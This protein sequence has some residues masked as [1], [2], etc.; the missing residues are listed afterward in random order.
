ML[1]HPRFPLY[2]LFEHPGSVRG[3]RVHEVFHRIAGVVADILDFLFVGLGQDV[4][5]GLAGVY[6]VFQF[7]Y[8]IRTRRPDLE[9]RV[10]RVLPVPPHHGYPGGFVGVAGYK[11]FYPVFPE[12]F[13]QGHEFP[14]PVRPGL[15]VH[16]SRITGD[17]LDLVV[18]R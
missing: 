4:F 11:P 6:R 12:Q 16:D 2:R 3:A 15:L 1:L 7:G 5:V 13:R 8:Q 10:F 9:R 18:V 14:K 17:V